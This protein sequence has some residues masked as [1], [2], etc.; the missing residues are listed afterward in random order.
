M[1]GPFLWTRHART[2]V[3][4]VDLAAGVVDAEHD[5]YADGADGVVHR[6]W[7]VAPPDLPGLLIVDRLTGTGAHDVTTTFPLATDIDIDMSGSAIALSRDGDHVAD[8]VT[9]SATPVSRWSVRGDETTHRGWSS[10]RLEQR[11]P[12]WW[13]GTQSFGR[14]TPIVEATFINVT[15]EFALGCDLSLSDDGSTIR[16]HLLCEG[17]RRE[18]VVDTRGDGQVS[19]QIE[20]TP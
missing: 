8:I 3:R 4:A 13:V 2:R 9:A 11:T 17:V 16:I 18:C 19:L 6:R 12:A 7:V 1:G 14:T 5:G 15:T 10:H 20:T